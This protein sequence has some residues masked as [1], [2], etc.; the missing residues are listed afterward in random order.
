MNSLN[1]T[2]TNLLFRIRLTSC[3]EISSVAPLGWV[4]Y[5]NEFGRY[6]LHACI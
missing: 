4:L 5:I 3:F 2:I 6:C 1:C